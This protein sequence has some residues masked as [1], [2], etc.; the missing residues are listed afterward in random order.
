MSSPA[1]SDPDNF[2]TLLSDLTRQGSAED[3]LE[4]IEAMEAFIAAMRKISMDGGGLSVDVFERMENLAMMS[5]THAKLTLEGDALMAELEKVM[6]EG[7][8]DM[9]AD[10]QDR[11]NAHTERMMASMPEIDEGPELPADV[12]SLFDAIEEEDADAIRVLAAKVD[13]NGQYGKF[14]HTPLYFAISSFCVGCAIPHLLLDLGSDP[15]KGMTDGYTPLHALAGKRYHDESPEA[16][17]ALAQRLVDLGADIEARTTSW[18]W[19][20]VHYAVSELEEVSLRAL[21]KAG[22]SIDPS[23]HET[24]P[25]CASGPSTL[26]AAHAFPEVVAV[27]LEFG[28]NPNAKSAD[29]ST[30]ITRLED[31]ITRNRQHI[32]SII[33][34]GKTPDRNEVAVSEGL[35]KSLELMKA[36][37]RS[38]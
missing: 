1:N 10:L 12:R 36:V 34:R 23:Y 35:Q 6:A 2:N 13:L 16:V 38:S 9:P 24:S 22:A 3:T 17:E 21:F 33:G 14:E 28:A 30:A 27:L 5:I 8:S 37:K 20:P 31:A 19:T 32:A 4:A 7:R 15:T 25:A 29:G 11:L 26:D 18:G